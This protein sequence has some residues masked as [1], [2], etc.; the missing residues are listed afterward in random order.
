MIIVK[1]CH[2][3]SKNNPKAIHDKYMKMANM[4]EGY[5]QAAKDDLT[6]RLFNHTIKGMFEDPE[7]KK[8][9]DDICKI[10]NSIAEKKEKAE[11]AEKEVPTNVEELV[12]GEKNGE[13][14]F[15]IS[16]AMVKVLKA[17]SDKLTECANEMQKV[18][19]EFTNMATAFNNLLA[20]G[21]QVK[22][23]QSNEDMED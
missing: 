15:F 14:T 4:V 11:D 13:L 19:A 23:E 12:E 6:T 20:Q 5:T 9:Y 17:Y 22:F 8:V 16:D 1:H 7:F 10:A 2:K 21:E 18:S 3:V